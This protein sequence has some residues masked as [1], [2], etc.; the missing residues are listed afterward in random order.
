MRGQTPLKEEKLPD[1]DFEVFEKRFDS[2]CS[3]FTKKKQQFRK[4]EKLKDEKLKIL[5]DLCTQIQQFLKADDFQKKKESVY[6]LKKRWK[7]EIEHI[8]YAGELAERF[9]ELTSEYDN[10]YKALKEDQSR[11]LV[12]EKET[13]SGFITEIEGFIK[14]ENCQQNI[15]RVKEIEKQWEGPHTDL[16]NDDDDLNATFKKVVKA[17]FKKLK[18]DKEA[19]HWERWEHF[20]LKL[21]LCE[22]ASA[23]SEKTDD[24]HAVSKSLKE[25][26]YEW[27]AIG[28]V[29]KA[30]AQKI[31]RIFDPI[32]NKIHKKCK[33]F[34]AELDEREKK[35]LV[36]KI[37]LCEKA[38]DLQDKENTR[39][40]A[41][42]IKKL[43]KEWKEIGLIPRH[44]ERTTFERFQMACNTFFER[45]KIEYEKLKVVYDKN[46]MEKETLCEEAEKIVDM[47]FKR[48]K[49][50]EHDLKWKWKKIG[51]VARE[52]SN[53]LWNKFNEPFE[54]FREKMLLQA[55]ENLT[56][57]EELCSQLEALVNSI[58]EGSDYKKL[59]NSVKEVE[60][61]WPSIGPAPEDKERYITSKYSS[62]VDEFYKKQD[63]FYK[64]KEKLQNDNLKK[65]KKLINTLES[66]FEPDN[67]ESALEEKVR[68]VQT[69]WDTIGEILAEKEDEIE[70]Q[71]NGLCDSFFNGNKKFFNAMQK[72]KKENLKLKIELCVKA[73]KLANLTTEDSA[74]ELDLSSLV[75][76]LS[77]AIGSNFIAEEKAN[78]KDEMKKIKENWEHIGD[79]P[80]SEEEKINKR[81][82]SACD[83]FK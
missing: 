35:N 9:S 31:W 73:E 67:E 8:S 24:M 41:D 79:V 63:L 45:R 70:R 62:V 47:D 71:Y 12:H 34:Y 21:K 6:K 46:M 13:L 54:K 59:K 42:G 78:P 50:F 80:S 37:A 74:M 75:D 51:H 40:N 2:I 55:P 25:F 5:E 66:V 83:S 30:E 23:L 28:E 19:R 77:F 36:L 52:D 58:S 15:T 64:E 53:P 10:K 69:Q 81:F 18:M 61:I 38:E 20:A 39:E 65:K 82:K 29:P 22:K 60:S 1:K 57:K 16:T 72:E 32:C 27:K 44:K 56:K 4:E 33:A 43:Q 49:S 17:Y 76:E 48:A 14:A 7:R 3:R 26:R 68:D 11:K